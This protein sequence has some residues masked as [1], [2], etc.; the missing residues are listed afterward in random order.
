MIDGMAIVMATAAFINIRHAEKA[1]A[2]IKE[3]TTGLILAFV[4]LAV[5]SLY[6]LT[7][8]V[9]L[10]RNFARLNTDQVRDRVGE[11][12]HDFA[13]DSSGKNVLMIIL[14]QMVRRVAVAALITFGA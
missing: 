3:P 14:I 1:H 13:I 11:A 4:A 7:L 12:Y 8:L 2:S 5:I 6:T 10:C 9:Y